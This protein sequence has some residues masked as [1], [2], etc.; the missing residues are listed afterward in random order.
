MS[1]EQLSMQPS[2]AVRVPTPL[3][4]GAKSNVGQ[5]PGLRLAKNLEQQ[6][7]QIVSSGQ[8]DSQVRKSLRQLVMGASDA[9]GICHVASVGEQI[10]EIDASS[11][12]GR[13]P[14]NESF[15]DN[16]I[17]ACE[18]A[19]ARQ[20]TQIVRP[21]SLPTAQA[22]LLPILNFGSRP[23]GLLTLI[24]SEADWASTIPVLEEI[25][26][27]LQIWKK[28]IQSTKA[29]WK[30]NSLATI[31]ELVS[32]LEECVD[33]Q[34][35]AEVLANELARHLDCTVA[36]GILRKKRP[37]LAAVSNA[38]QF[39]RGTRQ[40][41]AIQ[42]VL[43]ESLLRED[44]GSYPI[45]DSAE[46]MLLLAHKQAVAVLQVDAVRSKK[47][48]TRN[49][50]SVGYL[51]LAGDREV[52]QSSRLQKFLDASAPSVAS[53]L[54][55]VKRSERSR[56]FRWITRIPIWVA[57]TKAMLGLAFA[58]LL[59]TLMCCR[60]P[61]RIRCNCVVQPMQRRF[62]VAP[63]DGLIQETLVKPGDRVTQQQLLANMDGRSIRWDLT[64]VAAEREQAK[65]TR[66]VELANRNVP[67][68]MLAQYEDQRLLARQ[69]TLEF[70]KSNLE[71]RSPIEGI[72]L[73][74][75]PEKN[76]ASSVSTG[77][78]LFEVAPLYPLKVEVSI[79]ADDVPH[80]EEGMAMA[81][82]I[83]G[84]EHE[85]IEGVVSRIYPRSEIRDAENVFVAEFVLENAERNYRPG[86]KGVARI[87]SRRYP[88]AW[89]L[90]HKP[91]EHVVAYWF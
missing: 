88:L 18:S 31:V 6:L 20:S 81:I 86:M 39:S 46:E 48:S 76:N 67:K 19:V 8:S 80:V 53:A 47:L 78:L 56:W 64:S 41:W 40:T 9:I 37:R 70:K 4:R 14:A 52:I 72:V 60:F 45:E 38:T 54:D 22:L 66:E 23:E 32:K 1:K 3:G 59:L 58:A 49:S 36:V 29:E 44:D 62:V 89:N 85:S 91:F 75:S 28:S 43:N 16:L 65:K 77:D 63:F 13:V 87:K 55:V 71:I 79:P 90:F 84:F 83:D 57:K 35:A 2:E 10:W 25:A 26:K 33:R 34:N 50:K 73:S 69:K 24:P 21:E 27:A 51:V 61:Y 15:R 7:W 11:V 5:R 74:G 68:A 17:P 82:R 30:L 12:L 42:Q